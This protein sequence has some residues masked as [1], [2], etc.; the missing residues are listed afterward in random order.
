MPTCRFCGQPIIGRSPQARF[1]SHRCL[2]AHQSEARKRERQKRL[3]ILTCQECGQGFKHRNAKPKFCSPACRLQNRRRKARV[4]S[5][6][7]GTP[8]DQQERECPVCGLVFT[9][10]RSMQLYCGQQCKTHA[11]NRRRIDQQRKTDREP[12][13]SPGLIRRRAEG[14]RQK[15]SEPVL[16]D[17]VDD[18]RHH[19]PPPKPKPAISQAARV[20]SHLETGNAYGALKIA[21]GWRRLGQDREAVTKAWEAFQAG[22]RDGLAVEAGLQALRV[23]LGVG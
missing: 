23:R 3:V 12:F 8:A 14:I 16:A 15:W 22:E 4:R 17:T 1:C 2:L 7:K 10:H 20:R 18:G 9:T 5:R 13:V 19:F 11:L 21:A 6:S